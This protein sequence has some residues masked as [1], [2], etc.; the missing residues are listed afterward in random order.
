MEL[1]AYKLC[2]KNIKPK[3]ILIS[4]L[5]YLKYKKV[6]FPT[7]YVLAEIITIALRKF[8]NDISDKINTTLNEPDK[9]YL[10]DLLTYS[11]EYIYGN[12]SD[13]SIKTYKLTLLKKFTHSLRPSQ[14]KKNINEFKELELIFKKV[15]PVINKIGLSNQLIQYYAQFVIKSQVF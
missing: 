11:D 2:L 7:Y 12:K 14:I 15:E 3:V 1:E 10:D 13:R 8:D 4:L 9:L 6:E 5:D